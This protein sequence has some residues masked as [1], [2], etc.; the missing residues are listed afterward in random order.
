MKT[1]PVRAESDFKAD[2][3]DNKEGLIHVFG[4]SINLIDLRQ[5]NNG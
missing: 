3:I 1:T 5:Q 4:E 2:A